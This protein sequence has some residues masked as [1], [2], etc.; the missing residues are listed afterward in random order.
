[1][2]SIFKTIV[3]ISLIATAGLVKGNA[4]TR[5]H[6]LGEWSFRCP[7]AIDGFDTG[8]IRIKCDSICTEYPGLKSSYYSTKIEQCGEFLCFDFGMNGLRMNCVIQ[9]TGE[10]NLSGILE[11]NGTTLPIVLIRKDQCYFSSSDFH[12]GLLSSRD[13]LYRLVS[14]ITKPSSL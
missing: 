13:N 10:G 3:C 2:K 14:L 5:D 11:T 12:S 1:M 9:I 7:D 8:I 6:C 4:Q